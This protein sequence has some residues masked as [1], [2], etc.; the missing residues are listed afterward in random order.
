MEEKSYQ[1]AIIGSGPG[2]Y[3]AAL[4][5]AK[6]GLKTVLIEKDSLGGTC[7]NWGCIP[8]KAY[9]RSAQVFTEAQSAADYGVKV[10]TAEL[11]FPAVLARKDKIVQRLVKGID[12][13]LKKAE[14][15]RINGEASFITAEKIKVK[16]AAETVQ[17]RADKI[18][19]ATGSQPV[20]PSIC[21]A[22]L[23]G[24]LNSKSLL[25][26][27]KLPDSLLI[28]GGGVIGLEFAF[29]FSQF[30]V[31]VTV[32]EYLDQLLPDF[33]S[34]ISTELNRAARRR[35]IKVKTGAL[36][37]KIVKSASGYQISYQDK[38]ERVQTKQAE[39]VL[40]AV[41]RKPYLAGLAPEKAG[42]ELTKSG[43]IKVN[44]KMESNISGIYAVGDVTGKNMLAHVAAE[45]ALVAVANLSKNDQ[46]KTMNYQ[47]VP[48]A[49]FTEPEVSAVGLTESQAQARNIAYQVGTFPFAASGK[50]MAM[51]SREGKI[52]ILAEA[53]TGKIIGASIIGI[54]ASDLIA[55]LT[56]A[57]KEGLTFQTIAATIHAHP[58]TAEVIHEA[59]LELGLGAIHA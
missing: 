52:K 53:S 45:Q 28:I 4:Q 36:V 59:A 50:V 11:D 37:T 10:K 25:S 48:A 7:L 56:L 30:G 54:A 18:I 49:V 24:I 2:G 15:E 55:E 33:D 31:E 35:K 29:I 6:H 57:V 38:K 5:A 40:L 23:P 34:E 32:L 44:N 42:I 19:I 51:G 17:I 3:T 22:D 14:V 26:L 39:Q 58:T 12:Y 8:T 47:A 43:A 9:V 13:L 27:T 21:G 41:G 20:I 1:L 16:T 46:L